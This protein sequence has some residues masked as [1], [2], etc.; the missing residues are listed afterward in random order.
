MATRADIR[1]A[2][3]E[4]LTAVAGT[5]DVEDADGTVV[6]SVTLAA[7]NIGLRNPEST[8]Q[9]PHIV[10]HE[11]YRENVYNGVGTA[12]NTIEYD[13]SG[14]VQR[15]IWREYIEGQFIIDVRASNESVKEPLYEALRRQFGRYQFRPW[16]ETDIHPDV[17][18]VDVLDAQ[19]VDDG[20]AEDIVRG[21]QLEVRIEFQREYV[22]DS[23]DTGII[24]T[25]EHNMDV[26]YDEILDETYTTT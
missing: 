23:A 19:S 3:T 10:Y 4:E 1:D 15:A 26:D 12:P 20:E 14:V 17:V 5:Y 6:G 8:E 11:D 21:D 9:F 2:F 24:E 16:N 22:L 13:D 25:V 18:N 7:D